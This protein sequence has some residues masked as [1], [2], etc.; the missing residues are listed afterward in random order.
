MATAPDVL[1]HRYFQQLPP[2]EQ[3][4]YRGKKDLDLIE[5]P[6]QGLL[7]A[8][9]A[10]LNEALRNERQNVPEHVP[11]PPFYMDFVDSEDATAMAF[12]ERCVSIELRHSQV[13]FTEFY[14]LGV[15]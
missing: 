5:Q 8:I 6:L 7:R 13:E 9:Q 2:Y 4:I 1:F 12:T 11:H 15:C 3:Q 14:S 10:N